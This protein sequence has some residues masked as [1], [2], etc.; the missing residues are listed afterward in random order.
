MGYRLNGLET[1]SWVLDG[2]ITT[3]R[4]VVLGAPSPTQDAVEVCRHKP[5]MGY[6][7]SHMPEGL[8][9]SEG[10][11]GYRI[12]RNNQDIGP[13]QKHLSIC[14]SAS[15]LLIDQ[16]SNVN[17]PSPSPCTHAPT[18]VHFTLHFSQLSLF[19]PQHLLPLC[20]HYAQYPFQARPPCV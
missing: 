7:E 17:L 9:C 20:S 2:M 18:A 13:L 10:W 3:I 11:K 19:F 6:L 4:L 15:D 16:R 12:P 1:A 14:T 8:E 5:D